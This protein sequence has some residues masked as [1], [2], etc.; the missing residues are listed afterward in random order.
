MRTP[1]PAHPRLPLN[2]FETKESLRSQSRQD[3]ASTPPPPFLTLESGQ[4][5]GEQPLIS[6]PLEGTFNQINLPGTTYLS[7]E[8]QTA[9]DY[10]LRPEYQNHSLTRPS[11]YQRGNLLGLWAEFDSCQCLLQPLWKVKVMLNKT[12]VNQLLQQER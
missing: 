5:S 8:Q 6:V 4:V 7:G 1:K 2:S 10:P 12:E 3:R 11:E 9:V